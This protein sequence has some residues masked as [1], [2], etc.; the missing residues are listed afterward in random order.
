[1]SAAIGGSERLLVVV[2]PSGAGKDSVI[3]AW[4]ATFPADQRP[5]R[6]RRTITR[7]T[8]AH[9]DHEP[10]AEADFR[11]ASRDGGFA[12]EWEAHGLRYGIRHEELRPLAD[13]RW[14]VMNGSRHHLARLRTDAPRAHVLAIEAPAEVRAARLHQRGRETGAECIARLERGTLAVQADRTLVNDRRIE[15]AVA[16]L[17][18]WWGG[19]SAS[20]PAVPTRG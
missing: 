1:M 2:G 11:E 6:A 13:G 4:L 20:A 7:A 19:L 10:L 18:Q 17:G 14:V 8:D 16:A 3:A 15:D 5:H 12:F 9:E